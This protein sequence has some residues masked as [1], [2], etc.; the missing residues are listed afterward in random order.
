MA[1]RKTAGILPLFLCRRF[2][3]NNMDVLGSMADATIQQLG[4]LSGRIYCI[5]VVVV[6]VIMVVVIMVVVIIVVVIACCIHYTP[7]TTPHPTPPPPQKGKPPVISVSPHVPALIAYQKML[8]AGVSG[9]AV[10]A[11]TGELIANLSLSELRSIQPEHFG[12]LALPVGEFLALLHGTVYVG[13][14]AMTSAA[15]KHPFFASAASAGNNRNESDV[16]ILTALP[17]TTFRQV[18]SGVR[19]GYVVFAVLFL[20]S[21][22]FFLGFGYFF[23]S[24]LCVCA[25][26][27]HIHTE[28]TAAAD[29]GDAGDQPCA[30]HL[31]VGKWG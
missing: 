14:S 24:M 13:Y 16:R 9:A 1:A 8:D 4:L 19:R 23:A 15:A 25:C 29:G 20:P 11:D 17:T 5:I 10:V 31:C 3:H 26:R 18:C 7:L 22:V 30:P 2:L 6:V 12:A 21:R 28:H 27:K